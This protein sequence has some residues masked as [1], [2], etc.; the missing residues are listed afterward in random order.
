MLKGIVMQIYPPNQRQKEQLR[1]MFGNDRFVWNK[2]LQMANKRYENNPTSQFI[3][4]YA[5]VIY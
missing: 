5:I 4:A 3:N 2:I 1:Q